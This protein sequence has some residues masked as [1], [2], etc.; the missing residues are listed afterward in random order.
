MTT[1]VIVREQKSILGKLAEKHTFESFEKALE[2]AQSL[3]YGVTIYK[4]VAETKI[5]HEVDIYED[6]NDTTS[7]QD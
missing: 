4:S 5:K 1:Y 2:Y 3:T 6:T 7:K